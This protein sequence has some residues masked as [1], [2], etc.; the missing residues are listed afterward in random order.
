MVVGSKQLCG[1]TVNI[2]GREDQNFQW[3]RSYWYYSTLLPFQKNENIVW[4]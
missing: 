4:T 3:S 1:D 2:I